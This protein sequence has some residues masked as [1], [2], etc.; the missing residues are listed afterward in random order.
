MYSKIIG[1]GRYVP[2]KIV[3][4]DD[5]GQFLE[6]SD[7]WIYPRTGIRYRHIADKEGNYDMASKAALNA[8][9]NANVRADEIDLIIVATITSE[10]QTPSIAC[11]VQKQLTGNIPF[12]IFSTTRRVISILKESNISGKVA[13]ADF[14]GQEKNSTTAVKNWKPT[15][16]SL[17]IQT[18]QRRYL[19]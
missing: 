2:E 14:A 5:L 12:V 3:S 10:Y 18:N 6:T 9:E 8:L 13:S 11:I 17:F 1:T 15:P 16:I 4:N 7:D 19:K